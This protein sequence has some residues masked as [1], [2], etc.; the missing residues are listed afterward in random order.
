MKTSLNN[1]G[2]FLLILGTV[3]IFSSIIGLLNTL[4]EPI[5]AHQY[6]H[7]AS[8]TGIMLMLGGGAVLFFNTYRSKHKEKELRSTEREKSRT[9]FYE[10]VRKNK[11]KRHHAAPLERQPMSSP[12]ILSGIASGHR[13]NGTPKQSQVP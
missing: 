12:E 13:Q 10:Q 11:E 5:A 2:K 4:K 6:F 1:T 8:K 7:W 3:L 9:L